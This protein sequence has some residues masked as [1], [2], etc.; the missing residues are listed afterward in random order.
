MADKSALNLLIPPFAG[1]VIGWITN[2]VAIKLLFRPHS[3]VTVFGWKIQGLIPKRR[4]E[5]SRSI[6][7]AIEKDLLSSSDIASMLDGMEW[8]AE[9]EKMVEE[10]VEHRFTSLDRLKGLPVIG[11][12]SDNLK[13]HIKFLLTKEILGRIDGKKSSIATKFRDN[14]DIKATLINK[15][16][17]LDVRRFEGLLTEF[18]ARELK[19]LEYLG[20]IMG[21][22]IGVL[23]SAFIYFYG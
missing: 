12:L 16:D 18:I 2:W 4:K 17:R 14:V 5:I 21:F 22:L 19:H 7:K 8:K 3:P 20:G 10:M 11:L 15:I 9:V 13:Y 6:A 1:A 23:Q